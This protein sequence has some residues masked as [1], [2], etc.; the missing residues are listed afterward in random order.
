VTE[1]D[2][3]GKRAAIATRGADVRVE[4]YNRTERSRPVRKIPAGG[5][6]ELDIDPAVSSL[7]HLPWRRYM[8]SRIY[9]HD[10]DQRLNGSKAGPA[11]PIVDSVLRRENR[12]SS[13]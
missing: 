6:L 7:R 8:R 12:P 2:H 10:E 5:L 1:G 13:H 11:R 4:I 3:A 9:W